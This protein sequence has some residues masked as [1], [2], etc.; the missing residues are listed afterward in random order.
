MPPREVMKYD[1][2]IVGAGPAGLSAAIRLKQLDQN[3]ELSVCVLEK[4]SEVGAHII[5]GNVL[6]PRA[7]DEL[8]P[9]WRSD[10][11][12]PIKQEV[13][14]DKYLYLTETMAIPLPTPPLLE[15]HGNFITSLSQVTRWLGNKA[16]ELGVE[17]Y[18]GF[19]V[20]EILYDKDKVYGVA[21]RDVGLDK[22]TGEPTDIF[23]RG[24]ELHG[25]QILFA[26]GARGSCSE[27]LMN[28][29][30]LKSNVPQTYGLGVK[31][32]WRVPNIQ[33][34][35]VQHT[36]GWPL[37]TSTYGGSFLYHLGQPDLVQIGFVVGLDY[38][39]A[40]LSPYKE[41]QRFKHHPAIAE[42]L[43]DGE[44]IGYGARVI[45]EGGFQAIPK[46]LTVPGAAL[47]GCAAGF[48]NVPKIKGTHTA[49]KS[50]ILAAEATF[51][52]I[53]NSL[54]ESD[55][56]TR[57]RES[58][59]YNELRAVRNYK[60]SF[61]YAGLYGGA[62]Y[63]G[64]SAYLLKGR[65]PWT[66]QGK[67]HRDSETTAPATKVKSITYPKPDGKISFPLLENLAR[68]AVDH[69]DQPS[70]LHIKPELKSLVSGKTAK[71]LT[72]FAAPERNF[73]P[74]GVYEYV[75]DNDGDPNLIINAQNCIHCK[76]C[77]IK[78]P[79]E[80]IDWTVP[81]GGGGPNYSLT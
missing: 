59:V 32:V 15:N 74:A 1:V 47:I 11:D 6:E 63:S 29:F 78:M 40:H 14:E 27:S 43:V 52:A 4:G 76:C 18:P 66:F 39:N 49:M 61:E 24:V 16:E 38:K 13:T 7:L 31:E 20:S 34:G 69:I 45:N 36:L 28:K 46:K 33:P 70:H 64:I 42:H 58:W 68:S 2:V 54:T 62:I 19:S 53:Q 9:D 17:I 41:F 12:C 67:G 10:E 73:C 77:S 37:D 65:E 57:L 48:L 71:S 51:D 35:F 25:K 75:E 23:E 22:N 79:Y 26:E 30:H 80:Y 55:F 8:L 50:G 72:E 44:C 56:D 60:P 81:A 5:S 21:T 3:E